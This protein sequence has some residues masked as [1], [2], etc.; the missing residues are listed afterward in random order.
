MENGQTKN[1]DQT[2][3]S[4]SKK[5]KKHEQYQV[6]IFHIGAVKHLH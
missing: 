4:G 6:D 5:I 3:D 1:V 2:L